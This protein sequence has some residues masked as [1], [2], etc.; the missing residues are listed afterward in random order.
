[1]PTWKCYGTRWFRAWVL[2]RP[3]AGLAT[4]F[5]YRHMTH[6]WTRPWGG[7]KD[8]EAGRPPG[9]DLKRRKEM[10]VAP[11]HYA[12]R[13]SDPCLMAA[14]YLFDSNRDSNPGEQRRTYGNT[15]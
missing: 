14:R 11:G 1:V 12:R 15:Q 6:V 9:R 8:V 7:W 4:H 2:G 5:L 3:V 10:D 13:D